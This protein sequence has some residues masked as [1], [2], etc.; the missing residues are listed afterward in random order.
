[1]GM[2]INISL[3]CIDQLSLSKEI[4]FVTLTF[5][6]YLEEPF[7]SNAGLQIYFQW[8]SDTKTSSQLCIFANVGG[9]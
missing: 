5:N 2:K 7:R 1:M 4:I 6:A 3:I 9:G 8:G